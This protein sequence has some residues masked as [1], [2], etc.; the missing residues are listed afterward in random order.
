MLLVD[1]IFCY[2]V[3]DCLCK[4]NIID[5]SGYCMRDLGFLFIYKYFFYY[6]V[7]VFVCILC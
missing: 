4:E 1:V 6:Y 2:C 5:R 7:V 3:C